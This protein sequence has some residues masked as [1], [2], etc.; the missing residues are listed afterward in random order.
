[1][2]CASNRLHIIQS[3]C[4]HTKVLSGCSHACFARMSCHDDELN[5][6][7]IV[8]LL[9]CRVFELS[10]LLHCHWM[11]PKNTAYSHFNMLCATFSSSFH[12]KICLFLSHLP[13]YSQ[14]LARFNGINIKLFYS[15]YYD[16]HCA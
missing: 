11:P 5:G 8:L 14:A 13:R 16:W 15:A 1:M 12:L 4:S 3:A 2:I 9:P 6:N 7:F 10:S